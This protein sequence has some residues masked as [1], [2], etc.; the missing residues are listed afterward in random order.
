MF[1]RR[2]RMITTVDFERLSELLRAEA[3][4]YRW[5][6]CLGALRRAMDG[7]RVVDAADAHPGLVRMHS[8]V[9]L[10]DLDRARP[11]EV[12]TLVYP[13]EADLPAGKVS[14]LAPLGTALLGVYAPGVIYVAGGGGVRAIRVEAVLRP[15]PGGRKPCCR[16]SAAAADA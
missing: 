14:V 2:Q 7:A 9:R 1:R 5:A 3:R 13:D 15:A 10:R 16:P 12:L 4:T 6:L 11:P 8:T